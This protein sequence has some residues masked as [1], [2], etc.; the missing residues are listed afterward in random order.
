MAKAGKK[1]SAR[2]RRRRWS[3]QEVVR[4]LCEVFGSA[5]DPNAKKILDRLAASTTRRG[6]TRKDDLHYVGVFVMWWLARTGPN[7]NT[8]TTTK[9]LRDNRHHIARMGLQVGSDRAL[10]RALNR[11]LEFLR[12]KAPFAFVDEPSGYVAGART[13]P[14][15]FKQI[16]VYDRNAEQILFLPALPGHLK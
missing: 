13:G 10:R 12:A 4:A 15:E 14:G 8:L 16:K 6:G 11:G 7:R 5:D 9:F 2:G 1:S 3:E